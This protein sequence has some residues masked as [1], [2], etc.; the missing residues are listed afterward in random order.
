MNLATGTVAA[1]AAKNMPALENPF[2]VLT[3][4]SGPH[5]HSGST[6]PRFMLLLFAALMPAA[7]MAAVHYGVREALFMTAAVLSATTFDAVF[8]F[9]KTGKTRP[10]DGSAAVTGLLIALSCPPG[11]PLWTAPAGAFFAI[12]IGKAAVGGLGL[13]FLNPALAGRAF[14]LL[15][16]PALMNAPPQHY[17]LN[18]SQGVF[19]LLRGLLVDHPNAWMGAVSPLAIIAGAVVAR[20]LRLFDLTVPLVFCVT[21]SVMLW[22]GNGP[23]TL[24]TTGA[25]VSV[26]KS[27]LSGGLLIAA[28]FMATD[29]VT[30]PAVAKG[31]V[32]YALGCGV[33]YGLFSRT[34]APAHAPLHA[35]LIMNCLT[36]LINRALTTGFSGGRRHGLKQEAAGNE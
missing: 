11:L 32:L 17:S 5:V 4:S 12:V 1:S 30:S 7:I 20:S 26:L 34:E 10:F 13:N 23:E 31:R 16:F 33:L 21:A 2:P 28:F 24:L 6:T 29:P 3:L 19:D 35:I 27:A 14:L 36:P 18:V 9:I 15:A 25:L 8:L 22:L